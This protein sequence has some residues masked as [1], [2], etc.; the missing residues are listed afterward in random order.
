MQK[1]KPQFRRLLFIDRKIGEGRYPN[2][3]TLAKEWEVS[4]KTMQRDIN[5]LKWELDA[6]IEYSS[7]KHGYYYA[8][9]N[10]RMPT[11]NISESDL[12]AICIAEKALQQYKATPV[13]SKLASV[14][15]KIQESLP[16]K[17]SVH[18]SWVDSRI[19]F[20]A[21]PATRIDRE[22]WDAA[23]R[24]VRENRRLRIRHKL[25]GK[26]AAGEDRDI[27][28]YHMVGYRGQWYVIGHC[29]KSSKIRTFAMSR[30][31]G[32]HLLEQRFEIPADFDIDKLLGSHFGIMWSDEEYKIRIRFAS[33]V[34]PYIKEREWHPTQSIKENKDGSVVLSFTANHLNEVKDWALSWGSGAKVLAP[35]EL[36]DKVKRDLR[37][38]SKQYG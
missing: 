14:F 38:A 30:M 5:Y 13:Y 7:V 10:Y 15:S 35:R 16:N 6:P 25:P 29:H 17:V 11:L 3:T 27:D 20:F 21:E 22:V 1:F 32:A 33:Q 31:G 37:D 12:F 8:E 36:V 23:T 19:S 34:A 28:P 24:S 4:I 18:P 2:C 26:T 9:D